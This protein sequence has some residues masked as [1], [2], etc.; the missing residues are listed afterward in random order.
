MLSLTEHRIRALKDYQQGILAT[1]SK[2]LT[3]L[4]STRSFYFFKNQGIGKDVSQKPTMGFEGI[5]TMYLFFARSMLVS[6]LS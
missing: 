3:L 5:P 6:L 1:L 2:I 4:F